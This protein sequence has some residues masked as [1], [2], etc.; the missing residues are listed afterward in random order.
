MQIPSASVISHWPAANYTNPVTRGPAAIIVVSVLLFLVTTLLA[1]RIYTR[2]RIS[3]GFGLDD[4][5]ILVAYVPTAA[6]ASISFVAQ[7][8]FGWGRHVWD[9]PL[10]FVTPG[11]QLSLA[12]Q[13]LF[14]L[15]TTLTKLSMLSLIYRVVSIDN[16]RYRYIVIAVAA[17]VSLDG[18]IFFILVTFHEHSPVSAYWT[19]SIEPQMCINQPKH[20]LAAG[21]INTITDF[22]IV[23]IPIPYVRRL[24]LPRKQQIIVGSLFAGGVFVTAAGAVRT[25]VTF[26]SYDDPNKDLTWNSI[27]VLIVS[28]LELHI[29]IICASI[30][31][32][33][34]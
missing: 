33:K 27:S 30:P 16:S 17:F 25:A 31:S 12:S 6:F 34:P 21:C 5:L 24:K 8:D 32:I 29:G 20:L 9:I 7:V 4:V 2:L 1:I 14:D 23:L 13:L 11:L 19:L 28:A 3:K 22:I 26:M 15:S 18:L 10:N